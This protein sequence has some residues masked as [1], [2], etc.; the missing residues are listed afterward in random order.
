MVG[1]HQ[2]VEAAQKDR[3][4]RQDPYLVADH[5]DSSFSIITE[6]ALYHRPRGFGSLGG[7]ADSFPRFICSGR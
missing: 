4:P 6:S 5:G 7:A 2:G 1:A 3:R